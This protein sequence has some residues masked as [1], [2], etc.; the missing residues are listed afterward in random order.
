MFEAIPCYFIKS[1]KA[2]RLRLVFLLRTILN[3]W[4]R[5][6]GGLSGRVG[7]VGKKQFYLTVLS[8]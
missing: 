5:R 1:R 6:A 4:V 8:V 7:S 2:S 3:F